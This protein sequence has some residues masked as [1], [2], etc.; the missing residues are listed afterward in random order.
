M[1]HLTE[2]QRE[3]KVRLD[4]G[5]GAREIANELGITRNAVYQQI[6]RMRKYGVLEHDY[7]PTGQAPR[8]IDTE[9]PGAALLQRI[10]GSESDSAGAGTLALYNELRRTRDELDAITRRLSSIIPR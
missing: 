4:Q 5:R 9:Q 7:T 3:I 6:Q 10:I 2:R 1:A 8:E